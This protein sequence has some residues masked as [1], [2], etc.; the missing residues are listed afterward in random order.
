V[1]QSIVKPG[2]VSDIPGFES[3]PADVRA[4]MALAYNS[5]TA[6]DASL[7]PPSTVAVTLGP[8]KADDIFRTH[9]DRVTGWFDVRVVQ[10]Q[11]NTG[12]NKSIKWTRL[13]G[14]AALRNPAVLQRSFPAKAV[15][16]VNVQ[17]VH[18][19]W[20]LRVPDM[21]DGESSYRYDLVKWQCA[22]KAT[23]D[24]CSCAWDPKKRIH[25]WEPIDLSNRPDRN[26]PRW[27]EE[28]P[29]VLIDRAIGPELI[30]D[31]NFPEFDLL[32]VRKVAD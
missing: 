9:P 19:V 22:D 3:L 6:P 4:R 24:W 29:L 23:T 10:I 21:I 32:L 25:A 20:T 7:V 17:G 30:N 8:P 11:R 28:H 15:L 13:V 5:P 1:P 26:T 14:P 27:S 31:P 2:G 16:W 18:G 12:E